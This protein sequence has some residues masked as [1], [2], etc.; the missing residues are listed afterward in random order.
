MSLLRQRM[1]DAMI[2]RGLSRHTQES[3][4][5]AIFRMARY[6]RRD[7]ATYTP[8]DVQA[9]LLHLV[10]DRHLAYGT[11]NTSACAARFLYEIVLHRP[12]HD[13]QITM[14]KVPA[15]QPELLSRQEVARL[16]NACASPVHR[17]LLQTL[18]ASGLR[19]SEACALRVRDVDRAADRMC[20]RVEHGKGAYTRYSLL[21]PS[22]LAYLQPLITGKAPDDW[23]F[24][25]CRNHHPVSIPSA[26]RAFYAARNLAG[27]AKAGGIHGLRHAF[28][29]HL[30]E[31]SVDLFSIQ[32][33]LGH[34]DIGTTSRYLRLISPQFRPPKGVDPLDLL[35]GLPT[36]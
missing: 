2:Q 14:A 5:G 21:P 22:L 25:N 23:L 13:F 27:I 28:A 17:T 34:S 4:I 1:L 33:L 35:A 30:L 6:Y 20:L 32:K 31:G 8:D 18:Y 15:T 29:K 36:L 7:P 12:R 24:Y 16:F 10:K 19:V 26:Q 3:Y 9:Y 11:M